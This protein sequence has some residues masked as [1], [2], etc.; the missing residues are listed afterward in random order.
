M[1]L[2]LHF[3]PLKYETRSQQ[4]RCYPKRAVDIKA[5]QVVI[6]SKLDSYLQFQIDFKIKLMYYPDLEKPIILF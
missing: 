2:I 6:A 3:R 5:L 1:G 4:P